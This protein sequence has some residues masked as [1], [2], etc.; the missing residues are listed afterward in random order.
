[1]TASK[2]TTPKKKSVKASNTEPKYV[3]KETLQSEA[4]NMAQAAF[5]RVKEAVPSF[6]DVAGNIQHHTNVDLQNIADDA[7]AF[8]R[9]NPAVSIAAAAGIGVLIGI[10]AT[11]RA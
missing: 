1:M 2:T 4:E 11:K 7:S 6:E 8:V 10:L 9:R 3:G 5:D